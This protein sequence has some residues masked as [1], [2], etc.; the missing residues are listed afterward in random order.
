MAYWKICLQEVIE[1]LALEGG[2][3]SLTPLLPTPDLLTSKDWAAFLH[4]YN[5]QLENVLPLHRPE[6]LNELRLWKPGAKITVS[7]LKLFFSWVVC[8]T[9]LK[10]WLTSCLSHIQVETLTPGPNICLSS[11][12]L[13]GLAFAH[14]FPAQASFWGHRKWLLSFSLLS[15]GLLCLLMWAHSDFVSPP[16]LSQ[17]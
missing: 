4:C 17:Q 7:F 11:S 12:L 16:L 5:L 1:R 15:H 8:L 10:D 9:A 6:Q 13:S 14:S 3:L 2:H